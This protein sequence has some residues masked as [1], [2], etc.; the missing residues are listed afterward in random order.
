LR[1]TIALGRMLVALFAIFC[2]QNSSFAQAVG[3]AALDSGPL[4]TE[5]IPSR[6]VVPITAARFRGPFV[7]A[8]FGTG[9]CLDPDCWYV[10]TNYHVAA[11]LKQVRIKGA[12][13]VKRYLA[14]GANDEGATLNIL[15]SGGTPL[16][17]AWSRDLAILQL[18]KPLR[19]HHGLQFST[20]DPNIGDPLDV[21]AYPKGVVDPFRKLQMFRGTYRGESAD[22]LMVIDYTPNGDERLR[23]GASGGIVVDSGSGKVVGIFCGLPEGQEP[24]AFAV[25]VESLAEFLNK[26]LPFLAEVLFPLKAVA[27]T[28]KEDFYPKYREV[29]PRTLQRRGHESETNAVRI[30]RERAQS[31]AEGMRDFIAVQTFAWGTGTGRVEASDAYEIQVRNG[32]QEF[33]EYPDGKKW[34]ASPSLPGGPLGGVTSIDDWSA[35]PLYI[36][37]RVGVRIREAPPASIDGD[38][39]RVFQ[40]YGSAE[41]EPCRTRDVYDFLLFSVHKDLDSAP[42]GEVWTDEHEN[43]LRMSLHCEDR[44]W[45]W[46]NGETIVTYGWL[47][48]PGVAPRLVPVSFIYKAPYKKKLYWCRGQF[49]NYREFVSRARSLPELSVR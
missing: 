49:V 38:P 21:Y 17:Y 8:E 24:I 14:T 44:A 45:G 34:R 23:P 31:L 4:A 2:L 25:P 13:V 40:Y 30:L 9:F 43:I 12:K 37:T 11:R 1:F 5:Q 33:R 18:S 47:A 36:G 16:R 29:T 19:D 41:D 42:Y 20:E 28:E 46:G 3:S 35:L 22:G 7:Q 26:E 27:S 48:K 15:A 32:S 6:A 39:I 10:G